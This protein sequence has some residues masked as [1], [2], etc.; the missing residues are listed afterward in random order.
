M[1]G[2][3]KM[4]AADPEHMSGSVEMTY[5]SAEGMQLLTRSEI[6]SQW[7]KSDCGM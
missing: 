6:D 5:G 4:H 3:V 1:T 7:L 2:T